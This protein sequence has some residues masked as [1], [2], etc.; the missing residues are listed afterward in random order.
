MIISLKDIREG[1]IPDTGLLI[2]SLLGLLYCGFSHSLSVVIL[3]GISYALY[4]FYPLLKGQEGLGF[5]DVKMMA[6]SGLWLLPS[7]IPLFFIIGGSAGLLT[8][9]VWRLLYKRTRFPL[10]PALAI[11]LGFCVFCHLFSGK[12]I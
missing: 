10:A 1:I 3:G 12:D 8:A 7:D 9:V 2:L 4:K 6:C 11:A 5:G